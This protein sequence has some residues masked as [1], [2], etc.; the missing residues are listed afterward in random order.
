MKRRPKGEKTDPGPRVCFSKNLRK[1]YR[2]YRRDLWERN[3]LSAASVILGCEEIG[4][5]ETP[6]RYYQEGLLPATG[7]GEENKRQVFQKALKVI[8]IRNP[9]Q[10]GKNLTFMKRLLSKTKVPHCPRGGGTFVSQLVQAENGMEAKVAKVS[11]KT[12]GRGC[13]FRRERRVTTAERDYHHR[14]NG[15]CCVPIFRYSA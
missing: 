4:N 14:G 6:F 13:L 8:T 12:R 2:R 1:F 5:R 15:G 9:F 11:A 3:V 7:E 10:P